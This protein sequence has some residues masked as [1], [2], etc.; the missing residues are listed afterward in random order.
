MRELVSLVALF[1]G[2]CGAL[3][4]FA[5]TDPSTLQSHLDRFDAKAP[6][7]ASVPT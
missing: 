6:L 5:C 1:V 4:A 2:P 7:K 3:P